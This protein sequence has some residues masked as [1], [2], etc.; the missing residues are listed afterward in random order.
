MTSYSKLLTEQFP[1][2]PVSRSAQVSQSGVSS[3]GPAGSFTLAILH[4]PSTEYGRLSIMSLQLPAIVLQ[5][6]GVGDIHSIARLDVLNARLADSGLFGGGLPPKV[7][8]GE[9]SVSRA[10]RQS[11]W[12]A[13]PGCRGDCVAGALSLDELRLRGRFR[14]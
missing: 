4:S 8:R 3:A 6:Y 13:S 5:T 11:S 9:L 14:K 10:S 12:P 1:I 2:V 7:D